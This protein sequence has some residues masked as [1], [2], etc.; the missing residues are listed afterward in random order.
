MLIRCYKRFLGDVRLLD[1]EVITVHT[2]NPGS[3]P[4][5]VEPGSRVWIRDSGNAACRYLWSWEISKTTD[6]VMVGIN[7]LLSNHLVREV[8]ESGVIA[9]LG[10]YD[11]IRGEAG[12][13]NE[14]SRINPLLEKSQDRSD[15]VN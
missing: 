4:G 13:G 9:G 1:G 14:H 10:G 12:Y 5:C 8:I 3:M 6:G 11:I 15:T 7:T 2:S